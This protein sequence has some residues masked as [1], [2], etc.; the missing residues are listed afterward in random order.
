LNIWANELHRQFS[1][2]VQTANKYMKN[3]SGHKGDANQNH[4]KIVT[5]VKMAII[6][7]TTDVCEEVEEKESLY[8]V[9]GNAN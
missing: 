1:K 9:G 5:P 6:N 2:E 7:N 8:I 4:I 3:C